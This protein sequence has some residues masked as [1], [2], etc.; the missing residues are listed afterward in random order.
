M[1]DKIP[2]EAIQQSNLLTTS[3]GRHKGLQRHTVQSAYIM[4]TPTVIAIEAHQIQESFGAIFIGSFISMILFGLGIAQLYIYRGR[5]TCDRRALRYFVLFIF[6]LDTASAIFTAWWMYYLFVSNWGDAGIF[7]T[8]NWLMATNPFILGTMGCANHFF[9]AWRIRVLMP[10]T[11]LSVAICFLGIATLG[12]AFAGGAIFLVVKKLADIATNVIR[13]AG[14]VWLLSAAIGDIMIAAS[15]SWFLQSHKSG[16][17][18]SDQLLDRVIRVTVTNGLL[19]ATIAVIDLILFLS[20][21][22]PNHIAI[23]II[24]PRVY[25]NTILA[26]LNSRE[27]ERSMSSIGRYSSATVPSSRCMPPEVLVHVEA[28]Q[29]VDIVKQDA[30]WTQGPQHAM[31][32]S[33][34]DPGWAGCS[35]N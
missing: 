6:L 10:K 16:F 25:T 32:V 35:Q 23:A 26:S 24:L 22:K 1:A 4:S 31:D 28:H 12:G 15:I 17:K 19:T 29:M 18:A 7:L 34:S 27:P 13:P 33:K 9:F 14:I 21:D 3:E 2:T 5:F 11:W 30:E 8:G 20:S